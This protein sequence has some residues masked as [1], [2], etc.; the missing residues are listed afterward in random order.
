MHI[1]FFFRKLGVKAFAPKALWITQVY[2]HPPKPIWI[3]INID[4]AI[5]GYPSP[6]GYERILKNKCPNVVKG[7]FAISFGWATKNFKSKLHM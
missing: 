5:N 2:W 7:C 3:K 4:G 1:S 6:A